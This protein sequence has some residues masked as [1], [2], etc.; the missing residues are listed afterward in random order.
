MWSI[1]DE[2]LVSEL[3]YAIGMEYPDFKYEKSKLFH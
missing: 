3:E 1:S 2:I